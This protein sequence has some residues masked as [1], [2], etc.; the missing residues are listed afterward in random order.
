MHNQN[1]YGQWILVLLVAF[2]ILPAGL[3][4]QDATGRIIGVVTDPSG[5]V[6]PNAKVT[7]TNVAT[8]L[9]NEA[10]TGGD[11][12]YQ[13]PLLPIGS[14]KVSAEASGFRKSVTS[15][16]KLEINQSLKVDVTLEVGT[17]GETV[18]V[19]ATVSGVETVNATLGHSVVA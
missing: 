18:Q 4:A 7:V 13:I 16:Q 8:Q 17:T 19:E 11:G 2:L 5:S 15:A 9:S 6:I 14:Y 1:R 3:L 12:S 10:T